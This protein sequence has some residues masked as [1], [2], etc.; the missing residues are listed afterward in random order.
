MEHQN[1]IATP[2]RIVVIGGNA[3][4]TSFVAQAR[5][6]SQAE[7]VLIERGPH[8]GYASCGLPYHLS[9]AIP[10]RETLLP[11]SPSLFAQR[12]GVDVRTQQE[13]VAID[14]DNSRH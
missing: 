7:I 1:A 4:G 14:R 5:R 10:E 8:I 11:L 12:F 9:G 13:V 2:Q 3:G 6:R